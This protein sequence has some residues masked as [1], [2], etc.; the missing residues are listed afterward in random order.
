ME[1]DLQKEEKR[2]L[3]LVNF[4]GQHLFFSCFSEEERIYLA[5]KCEVK[6]LPQNMVIFKENEIGYSGYIIKKGCV[7]IYKEGFLG[8]EQI[9]Q[10]SA[11]D[12]FGEMVLL[13]AFPRS[14]SAKTVAESELIEITSDFYNLLK[15][16]K[17]AIAVK[18]MDIFLKLLNMRLRSTTLKLYGQF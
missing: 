2:E 17:P 8:E 7:K 11:G 12:V 6:A 16:E 14:A 5:N 13:D 1:D 4:L 9:V 15:I 18:L 10:F 3:S